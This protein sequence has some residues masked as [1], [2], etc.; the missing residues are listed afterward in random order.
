LRVQGGMASSTFASVGSAEQ[1]TGVVVHSLR[2]FFC[3]YKFVMLCCC[4]NYFGIGWELLDDSKMRSQRLPLLNLSGNLSSFTQ[5]TARLGCSRH[6]MLKSETSIQVSLPAGCRS[7]Q[8]VQGSQSVS[9]KLS[10]VTLS[11]RQTVTVNWLSSRSPCQSGSRRLESKTRRWVPPKIEF[12]KKLS[13]PDH[14]FFCFLLK[15]IQLCTDDICCC[16]C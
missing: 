7:L 4:R 11:V 1:R 10:T 3:F 9:D 6:E 12:P 5:C 8:R 2:R 15:H 14:T 16:G 13:S